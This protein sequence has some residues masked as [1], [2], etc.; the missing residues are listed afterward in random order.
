MLVPL[1]WL[2]EFVDHGMGATDLAH[3]LT[4]SGLEVE[5]II[6]RHQGLDPVV[7]AKVIKVEPHPDADRLQLATVNQGDG[8]QTVVCGAP[9][10]R[11]GLVTALAL[12][13]AVVGDGMK[14]KKAKIRGVVSEGMLASERELGISNDHSGIV[15]LDHDLIPGTPL[16]QALNL[17]TEVLEIGVTPN[18]GDALS[19]LGVA[20]DVSAITGRPLTMPPVEP[21][22]SGEAIDTQA[23]VDIEAPEACPRYAARMVRGLK[24]GPSP[25]WLADRLTAC[26]VRPISN[27]VDVTNYVLMEM[28]QPLHAFDFETLA[29]GRIIVRNAEAGEKFTTLDGVERELSDRML[30]ICD[31]EKPVGLAGVMGG[32]NSEVEDSTSEVLIEAAFFEPL[33]IRRTSKRLGLST[34]ASFRFERTIDQEGCLRAA[35]RSALLMVQLAG[36]AVAPGA[37]DVH[38]LPHQRLTIT[39]SASRIAAYLGVEVDQA[40]V[41]DSMARLGIEA[42]AG[43]DDDSV[44][45][46]PPAFRPD[47][48][49][50]VDISEEVARLIGF[51]KIPTT[52]P[53]VELTAKPRP[54]DHILRN[55][56]RD[57][58]AAA[59]FD[60][61]LN[62]SFAH[63]AD[64]DHLRLAEDDTLRRV[65][66]LLNP[67]SEE[68]SV[69]RTSLLP[70]LLTSVRR[71]LGFRVPDVALFEI[72]RVFWARGQ[73][74]LPAEPMRLS[75]V[76]CG[77]AQPASWWGG[78]QPASLAHMRGAAAYLLQ[79]LGLGEGEFSAAESAPNWL[80]PHTC[81]EVKIQG[82]SLGLAGQVH[83]AVAGSYDVD[84][85]VFYLELDLDRITA[86]SGQAKAFRSLGR[87]PGITLDVAMVVDDA[88]EAGEVI[89]AASAKTKWL[90]GVILFDVYSGKPLAKGAKSL[91]LRFDYRDDERTLTEE[92]VQGVH[93]ARVA[94]LIERFK[95][96]LRT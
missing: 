52:N 16:V 5:G 21:P 17:E 83:A 61:A 24:I 74:E 10:V 8:Q 48:E 94:E 88:V 41:L 14:V 80:E 44:V 75:A 42:Q 56:A 28:G 35:N 82:K 36:G 39:C 33:G 92:E 22:T 2:A 26:G 50:P 47:L 81:L 64:A 46:R 91:G 58:M 69:L 7:V 49:R 86:Q 18:R 65:I 79:G 60:E 37:I 51:D 76:L 67:L 63:P 72:G 31:G 84:R 25:L 68:Q 96:Q 20:R 9:N 6:K 87:Y 38:P 15:E 54:A 43:D 90:Q 11:E 19:I 95:G 13:G 34:E 3:A 66:K 85:P 62:F 12:P 4:M 53:K 40:G 70:G 45:V 73:D 27:V 23:A 78:E 57:L 71:N 30:L 1:K 77:L 55:Q 32:L 89:D 93:Q 59:G 29:Q